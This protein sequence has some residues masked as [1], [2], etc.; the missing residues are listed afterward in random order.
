MFTSRAEYRLKL[1]ADNA[2]QRLTGRGIE[3]GCVGAERAR[4]HTKKMAALDS[5]R[6]FARSRSLTP[7]EANR[8]GL[9]L[10]QDGQRRTALDLLSYPNLG[11]GDLARIWPEFGAME[12]KIAGQLETDAKYAVYLDR[13][14]ADVESF[15]HD[16]A[17]GL[18]DKI[19]YEAIPGLSAELRQKLGL[20]RPRTLGQANRIDGMT[21]A[22]L[23]L[24]AL[25]VRRR[26]G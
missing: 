3:F 24:V 7:N 6:A 2:D 18:P 5:A 19:D 26:A 20:V 11:V 16:E 14:A 12:P 8:F 17:M 13:Q 10:N 23:G 21:P 4:H 22:A 1:R 25:H 9:V 15:R